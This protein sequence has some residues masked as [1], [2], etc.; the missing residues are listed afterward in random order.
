[1]SKK[2]ED[3]I[4]PP[5]EVQEQFKKYFEHLR[6]QNMITFEKNARKHIKKILNIE[7]E[8]DDAIEDCYETPESRRQIFR[9]KAQEFI[10]ENT[11]LRE[12]NV[13]LKKELSQLKSGEIYLEF[14]KEDAKVK[15]WR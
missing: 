5:K 10:E 1:M 13:K 14:K 4:V 9:K 2:H 12:E 7:Q 8:L 3:F 11:E 6:K 15:E